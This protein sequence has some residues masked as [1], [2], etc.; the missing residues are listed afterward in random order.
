M[1]NSAHAH[2]QFKCQNTTMIFIRHVFERFMSENN[3]V[4]SYPKVTS[5]F[6]TRVR[7]RMLKRI[8]KTKRGGS[9]WGRLYYLKL[10]GKGQL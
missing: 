9:G 1:C 10:I 5:N 3:N 8:S 7:P 4:A 2:A 6:S